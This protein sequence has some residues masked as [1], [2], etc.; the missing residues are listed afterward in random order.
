VSRSAA[1]TIAFGGQSIEI[2]SARGVSAK[3]MPAPT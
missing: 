1:I 3:P 2:G